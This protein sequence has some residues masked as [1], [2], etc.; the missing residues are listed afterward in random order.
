MWS[1]W[2]TNQSATFFC[3]ATTWKSAVLWQHTVKLNLLPNT[4]N[5]QVTNYFIGNSEQEKHSFGT[6]LLFINQL[7][8]EPKLKNKNTPC[9]LLYNACL[10]LD[11]VRKSHEEGFNQLQQQRI[12]CVC[13]VVGVVTGYCAFFLHTSLGLLTAA[14]S[15]GDFT[16]TNYTHH[17]LLLDHT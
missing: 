9:L 14:V 5:Y 15:I 16:L 17:I 7:Q 8:H 13:G 12:C 6:Q 1:C 10:Q 11:S 2:K 3:P 4:L